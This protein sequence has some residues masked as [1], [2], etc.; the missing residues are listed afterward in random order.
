MNPP[1]I[2]PMRIGAGA[3]AVAAA[4]VLA[5]CSSSPTTTTSDSAEAD[6]PEALNITSFLAHTG[7]QASAV[8]PLIAAAQLA[9]NDINDAGGV[10]GADVVYVEQDSSSDNDTAATAADSV[11]SSDANIVIGPYGSGMG[12][13]VI[14]QITE[15]GIVE[16]SGSNTSSALTGISPLY[17]RTAPTDA[18]ES[19]QLVDLIAADGHSSVGLIW[20]NDAWGAAFEEGMVQNLEAA[21]IDVAANESFNVEETDYSAQVNAVVAAQPDAVVFLSYAT[22]SGAM[23][24]QLVGT[25]GFPSA[26]VYFSSSTLGDYSA[27]VSNLA[28]LEGVQAFQPGAD[29]DTEA[30]FEARVKE[31]DPSLTAFAYAAS[32]YDAT[33]LAALAAEVAGS[34]DGEDI[35]AALA[36]ISGPNDGE[37]CSTYA[38]CLAIIEDGG[39]IDYDGLTGNIEFDDNNDVGATN[40]LHF[41]YAADGTYAV[42]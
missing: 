39:T 20:Q 40:Y 34:V 10:F 37:S 17:F 29:V 26:N 11:I 23:I 32:T 9:I 25:N 7:T 35:A 19:A 30:D 6:L 15:A 18:L 2:R 28:Y 41:V 5:S 1:T 42:E 31:I 16:I 36:E 24:E 4:L 3:A 8:A 33:I 14:P 27:S 22:Y 13:A 38:D 21:G 12:A